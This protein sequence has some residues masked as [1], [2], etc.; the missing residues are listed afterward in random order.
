MT[1]TPGSGLAIDTLKQSRFKNRLKIGTASLAVL[2]TIGWG[3]RSSG[4]T[5]GIESIEQTVE[6]RV[7]LMQ[8][9][10][11]STNYAN[12]I[13]EIEKFSYLNNPKLAI[14]ADSN[15]RDYYMSNPDQLTGEFMDALGDEVS[16]GTLAKSKFDS[17]QS[18]FLRSQQRVDSLQAIVFSTY[19]KIIS[20]TRYPYFNLL[21]DYQRTE[22][23]VG[24]HKARVYSFG[25]NATQE[26]ITSRAETYVAIDRD[27]VEYADQG[28]SST[29]F[30]DYLKGEE[31]VLSLTIKPAN[32]RVLK[33][34][35][36]E[37]TRDNLRNALNK[38]REPI[39]V[40][41]LDRTVNGITETVGHVVN[42]NKV[43]D[44]VRR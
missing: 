44:L 33:Y 4:R 22:F 17:L 23:D 40:M 20:E 43:K 32:T 34:F 16:S 12:I 41:L 11:D 42:Q 9:Q 14:I 26:N 6:E 24:G 36:D 19:G 37:K 13:S 18:R 1:T 31:G 35:K 8:T 21:K 7:E 25:N 5:S 39:Y 10:F 28:A 15:S 30:D 3:L 29:F 2:L 38:A 27:L